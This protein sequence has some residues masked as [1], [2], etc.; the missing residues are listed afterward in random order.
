MKA[1]A[2]KNTTINVL[3]IVE[4]PAKCGKIEEYLGPGYK[5]M[6][7][8]GHLR[9]LDGLN[10][11]DVKNGFKPTYTIIQEPI[12]LKQIEK[13]R[14]EIAKADDII[15]ATDSDREGEAIAWHL[16][17]MFGLP[18]LETKRIVFNEITEAALQSAIRSPTI[19]NMDLVYA[20][21][22]RQILDLLVGFTITPFLW[23]CISGNKKNSLSAGRCQ[24]PALRLIYE[25]HLEIQQ[26]PGKLL[27]DTAGYFTNM[28]LRFDLNTQFLTKDEVRHFL[29][30][31]KTATFRCSTTSPKKS[32][33]KAPEPLTTSVL[34][35]MASNDLHMSPKETMKAAQQL[36]EGGYITYMRTD[37]KK[38]SSEFILQTKQYIESVY[39]LPYISQTIDALSSGAL[40]SGPLSSDPL[41]KISIKEKGLKDNLV[42]EAHEAIRP[43]AINIKTIVLEDCKGE[44]GA[45]A[46]KLYTLIW[47]RTLESC[48]PSAQYNIITAKILM[49]P[50]Y[51]ILMD[52]PYKI[53]MDPPYKILMDPPNNETCE[54]VYKTE[55]VSF[56]GWQIVEPKAKSEAK[57]Y[58]YFSTMKQ[59]LLVVPKKIESKFN[60][61]ELKSHFS[62]ARLVQLL[63]EKGIGRPS[64][65]ASLIDK[66][67]EREYVSKQ[68]IEGRK[69]ECEDL[70]LTAEKE[71]IV[72][73]V[74]REFGNEKNKLVINPL[75]IIV[76][77]FLL[78]NFDTFFNYDY[79]RDMENALD[80]IATNKRSW[81]T[82]CDECNKELISIIK[83]LKEEPKFSIKIDDAHTIIMGK[84]G[85]VVRR[86][87]QSEKKDKLVTFLPIKKGLDI[88]ALQN[89]PD[90]KLE[91]II[92]TVSKNKDAIGKYKGVDL[93]IKK[94][95]Y[96]VY[97][98]W[99]VDGTN[100]TKPLKELDGK[101]LD[102]IEYMEV[103]CILERYLVLDPERPVGFVR[104]LSSTLSIRNGKFGDYIFY[105]KPRVKTPQF[106]KLKDFN[107]GST[108]GLDARKCDKEVLLNWIKLTYNVE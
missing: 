68:N 24:T 16:C 28:N 86:Q 38:Y 76:M 65:F 9:T 6:A 59:N 12:K 56:A 8:F 84:F 67:Q 2:Q 7:S 43:V 44:I 105:K 54:F 42:Q 103:L 48:M 30:F 46:I 21:Q 92:D 57:E 97:A 88:N 51:K 93:F 29:E 4:S 20:Q 52:P 25:N 94:G 77:E 74:K 36:Y 70:L 106:F 107:N 87:L 49:D 10:A 63:E 37:S 13:L 50:P 62:E 89:I 69:I 14:S 27:Y 1:K 35:Q 79:T 99:T 102:Q 45:K 96:G 66:I 34:Q 18:I 58:Q 80:L 32:I 108:K 90:L 75:G 23:K 55:Q 22:A 33:R 60:L 3:V 61:I 71:I 101:P 19:V 78:K 104:E 5:V 26:S 15:L 83:D 40:S 72:T 98:Q 64:T 73:G 31:C 95:K 41:T 53:L 47:K 39:G 11:I 91:D 100:E 82:L 81:P 85:P 17:D